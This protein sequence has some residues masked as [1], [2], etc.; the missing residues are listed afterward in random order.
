MNAGKLESR[1]GGKVESWKGGK[2]ERWKAGKLEKV[3]RLG[4]D[5]VIDGWVSYGD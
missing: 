5:N 4:D 1:K 3:E 2:L